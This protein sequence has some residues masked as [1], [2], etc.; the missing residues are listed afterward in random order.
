MTRQHRLTLKA[1]V[2]DGATEKTHNRVSA[3]NKETCC[4]AAYP[5]MGG[6]FLIVATL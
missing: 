2:K 1:A 4:L 3:K 5:R 6:T